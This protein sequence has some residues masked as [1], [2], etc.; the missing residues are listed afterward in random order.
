[1]KEFRQ[2]IDMANVVAPTKWKIGT[3]ETIRSANKLN[4][5]I[6]TKIKL[7]HIN[8]PLP[9]FHDQELVLIWNLSKF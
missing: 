8:D 1:M 7:G 2:C 6:Q 9:S 5:N 4:S 3:L